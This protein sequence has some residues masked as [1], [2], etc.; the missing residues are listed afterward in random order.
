MGFA[1]A[2][3]GGALVYLGQSTYDEVEGDPGG[4]TH[5]NATEKWNMA[6]NQVTWGWAT[7]GTGLAV[8]ASGL[9]WA[10]MGGEGD[11]TSGAISVAPD[12]FD[13]FSIMLDG[14]F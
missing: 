2:G 1:A 3:V 10:A 12:V 13:G 9:I 8:A 11:K 5:L 6:D 7:V 14:R 4:Y